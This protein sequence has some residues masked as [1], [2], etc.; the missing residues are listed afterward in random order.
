[1][2]AILPLLTDKFPTNAGDFLQ[3][4]ADDIGPQTKNGAPMGAPSSLASYVLS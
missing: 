4:V 1:M 2:L 3:V